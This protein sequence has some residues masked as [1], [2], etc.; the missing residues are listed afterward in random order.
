MG[1]HRLFPFIFVLLLA[2][3]GCS[4]SSSSRLP[5]SASEVPRPRCYLSISSPT[6][7]KTASL[8][9]LVTGETAP[10][11][12][13]SSPDCS[14]TADARGRFALMVPLKKGLNEIPVTAVTTT[15]APNTEE[16]AIIRLNPGLMSTGLSERKKREIALAVYAL[17]Q[18]IMRQLSAA[19]TS[20]GSTWDERLREVEMTAE[21]EMALLRKKYGLTEGEMAAIIDEAKARGWICDSLPAPEP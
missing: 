3:A 16:A 1:R 21:A 9:T 7:G 6:G 18:R 20:G 10:R 19:L 13:I 14:T 4:S 11:A 15:T 17:S 12:R 8:T 5:T 2:P